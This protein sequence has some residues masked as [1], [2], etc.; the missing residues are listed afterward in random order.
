MKA[1]TVKPP[2]KGVNISNIEMDFENKGGL[3][4]RILENGVCGTDREIVNGVMHAASVPSGDS[5]MVLGHEAIGILEDDGEFLKKG[6]I[7]M[8]V[9]RRGCGKCLN[10]LSG[11]ADFC[12]TGQFIEAGISGMHGFMREKII[13][14]EEYLVP[15]PKG[16]RDVAILAQ[17]L[18]DLEKSLDEIISVQRRMIWT[19]RDGTYNCRK[20]LII[21]S[22]PIGIL[23]C[24]LLRSNGF[25]TYISNKR[26][27]TPKEAKIFETTGIEYVNTTNGFS[28]I[29]TSGLMFDLVVEA[30]GSAADLVTQSVKMLKNNGILGLFGFTSSGSTT[31]NSE[32]L[33]KLVYRS[34]TIVGLINGQKTH[35]Q[36][37]MLRLAEW[38]TIWPEITRELITETVSVRDENAL[39]NVLETKKPGE[40]KVKIYW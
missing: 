9:N 6:D 32:D 39:K 8:P 28:S 4:I 30:S 24:L 26:E 23:M 21:G 19:C 27:A 38:N 29:F 36:R 22:G 16:I 2:Y 11:R 18:S 10:C 7:V 33:Q 40:I 12:E 25:E 37:A 20:A 17:P 31:L 5:Y 34:L 14:N 1:I 13:D 15:V 3:N 35:F